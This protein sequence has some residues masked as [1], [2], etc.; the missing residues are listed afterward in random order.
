MELQVLK[1]CMAPEWTQVVRK[2][3]ITKILNIK[4]ITVLVCT[5]KLTGLKVSKKY[6]Q[7][8]L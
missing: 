4:D 2:L 1:R 7:G 6:M 5:I 8:C 3:L